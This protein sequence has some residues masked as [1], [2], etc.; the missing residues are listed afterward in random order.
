MITRISHHVLDPIDPGGVTAHKGREVFRLF[1]CLFGASVIPFF[2]KGTSNILF[3]RAHRDFIEKASIC[4][5]KQNAFLA[6]PGNNFLQEKYVLLLLA[7]TGNSATA[8]PTFI[9]DLLSTVLSFK[10]GPFPLSSHRILG[11]GSMMKQGNWGSLGGSGAWC[12]F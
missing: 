6:L 8:R 3:F 11:K 12:L 7:T 1:V 2:W 10:I 9:T 5:S 4:F